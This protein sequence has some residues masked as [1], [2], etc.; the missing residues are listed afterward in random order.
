[1]RK[2]PTHRAWILLIVVLP[3]AALVEHGC[4]QSHPAAVQAMGRAIM[5]TGDATAG[6]IE[7]LLRDDPLAALIEARKR[8]IQEHR[9]Y[10]CN[11]IRQ[12]RL[13]SGMTAEQEMEVKF[14]AQPYSVV[15]E[16]IRN[17]GLVDRVIYVKDKWV[18]HGAED[19]ALRQLVLAQPSSLAGFFIKSTKQ[20]VRGTYA[21][22]SSRHFIDEF[23]FE[24]TLQA[25]IKYCRRAAQRGELELEFKGEND[26][27]GR[28]VW[29]VRRQLPYT[30]GDGVY[31]DRLADMYIDKEHEVPVAIY[32]YSDDD[33]KPR[34]LLGKYEFSN[35]RFDVRLTE[36]DFEPKP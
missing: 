32:C 24:R 3:A 34:N 7:Q 22:R 30:P 26:F 10:T 8:L 23:G 29:L 4:H 19:P 18:D 2:P 21:R 14:R 12:E 13:P 27:G 1:M 35:I 31:P 36:A 11:F 25:F 5:P 17:T 20:P 15:I 33:R 28:P 16:W 6:S 9:N